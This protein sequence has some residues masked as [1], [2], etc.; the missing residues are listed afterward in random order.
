MS[1]HLWMLSLADYQTVWANYNLQ[2]TVVWNK[3]AKKEILYLW[4]PASPQL[5]QLLQQF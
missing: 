2:K 3:T 4:K 1:F 5:I